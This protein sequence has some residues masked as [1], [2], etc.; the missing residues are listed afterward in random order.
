[1]T[2]GIDT[3]ALGNRV[4]GTS[5]YIECLLKELHKTNFT[6]KTFSPSIDVYTNKISL[7]NSLPIIR[8]GGIRRHIFRKFEL[9]K[10]MMNSGVNYGFFPNYLMPLNFRKPAAIIIHD[11]S[12]ISHPHFYSKAFVWYYIDQLK[13]VLKSNP[14]VCTV[15][16]TTRKSIVKYLNIDKNKIFLLQAYADI[17]R[18]KA[19]QYLQNSKDVKPYFLY[20]GHIEPRKNLFFMIENFLIWKKK[21]R[22][23]YKLK[24]V[25]E[26]WSSS[27][28]IHAMI[29]YFSKELDVEFCGYVNENE[30]SILYSNAS[31]FVHTSFVEG[32]GFPVLEA[33]HYGLPILCSEGTGTEEISKPYSITIDSY[34]NSSLIKG[35]NQLA[36][37]EKHY[38]EDYI[39]KYSP[40]LMNEQLDRLLNVMGNR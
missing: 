32:F 15:S 40:H 22:S 19:K 14:I 4:T 24:L 20:V 37:K 30:L 29:K 11:L 13:K 33:M 23:D 26:I 25:G 27:K 34:D 18:I 16:E 5:R 21:S 1:V 6:I 17:D 8:R 9:N 36:S 31:A 10:Q 3:S 38:K 2:I 7:L 28:K 12:F 35:F 39:I